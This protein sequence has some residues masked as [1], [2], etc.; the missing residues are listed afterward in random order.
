MDGV[1]EEMGE[2]GPNSINASLNMLALVS[3]QKHFNPTRMR[4]AQ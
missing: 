2:R 3:W 1:G 4:S